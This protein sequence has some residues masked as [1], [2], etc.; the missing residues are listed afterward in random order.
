MKKTTRVSSVGLITRTHN[1]QE[2]ILLCRLSKIVKGAEGHWTLPGG[3]IEH[4]ETPE[5]SLVREVREETG[6]D[7][8]VGKLLTIDTAVHQFDHAQIHAIRILYKASVIHGDF[9]I[10]KD[11]ST[12]DAHW[13]PYTELKATIKSNDVV[14]VPWVANI[15][16]AFG[17]ISK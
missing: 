9:V 3:Q 16:S 12:D 13:F 14:V 11:G 5:E 2:E 17:I 6:L 15:L 8:T 10:E 4:G 1:G 7:A